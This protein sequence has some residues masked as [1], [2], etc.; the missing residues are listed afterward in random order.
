MSFH[1]AHFQDKPDRGNDKRLAEHVTYVHMH[2]KEPEAKGVKYLSMNTIRLL[3][4]FYSIPVFRRDLSVLDFCS[5][6]YLV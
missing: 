5:V 1:A 2:G 3:I 4:W 6:H